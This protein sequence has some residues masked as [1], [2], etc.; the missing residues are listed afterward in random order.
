M[1]I[2]QVFLLS[3]L[4]CQICARHS[5][6][7][8][9]KSC[10][11]EHS[12][13]LPGTD[14]RVLMTKSSVPNVIVKSQPPKCPSNSGLGLEWIAI[15]NLLTLIN[16]APPAA[17]TR[18][19]FAICDGKPSGNYPDPLNC[20]NAYVCADG[21]RSLVEAPNG[22]YFDINTGTF[23]PGSC[24]LPSAP[25]ISSFCNGKGIGTYPDASDCR[26]YFDC[27]GPNVA[28]RQCPSGKYYSDASKSCV[29]GT[30]TTGSV[31]A[32]S[33]APAPAPAPAPPPP[34]PTPPEALFCEGKPLGIYADITN[35]RRYYVCQQFVRLLQLCPEGQIYK[36]AT[37]QCEIGTCPT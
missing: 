31:L 37:Q 35:C 10:N 4:I 5:G 36:E 33:P 15:L 7:S 17:S 20:R 18:A 3:V 19:N 22:N 12:V 11:E 2:I 8:C 23:K 1:K 32:P 21:A 27:Q 30:C 16:R 9:S 26:N 29:T 6:E 25:A 24:P 34:A 14:G 28:L 13:V